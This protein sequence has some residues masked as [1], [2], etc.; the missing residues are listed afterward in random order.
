MRSST[1][2]SSLL[3]QPAHLENCVSLYEPL[4]AFEVMRKFHLLSVPLRYGKQYNRLKMQFAIELLCSN[5]LLRENK[6]ME[7]RKNRNQKT[8]LLLE[9][10]TPQLIII[11]SLT[12]ERLYFLLE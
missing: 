7:Q 6:I 8:I 4:V 9:Y 5:H 3:A 2:G 1:A 11:N 10:V 12:N